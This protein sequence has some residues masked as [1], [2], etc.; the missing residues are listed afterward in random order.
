MTY[1][2]VEKMALDLLRIVSGRRRILL[3]FDDIQSIRIL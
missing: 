2:M 3:V 1:P